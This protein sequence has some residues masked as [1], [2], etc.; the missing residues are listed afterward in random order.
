MMLLID[1]TI[2]TAPVGKATIH[3]NRTM[4]HANTAVL[5]RNAGGWK[6]RVCAT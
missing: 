1:A 4:R 6:G 2:T 3:I 5:E